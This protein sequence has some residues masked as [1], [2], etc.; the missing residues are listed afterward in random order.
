MDIRKNVDGKDRC[1]TEILHLGGEMR[2]A[3]ET[4]VY[5]NVHHLDS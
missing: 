1:L 5:W 4:F 3:K 2:K